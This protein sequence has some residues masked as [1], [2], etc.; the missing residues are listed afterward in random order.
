MVNTMY[1]MSLESEL[2]LILVMIVQQFDF[3]HA[4]KERGER[5]VNK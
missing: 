2:F 5:L 3:V 4:E 1:R